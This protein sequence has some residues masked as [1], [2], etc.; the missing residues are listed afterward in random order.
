MGWIMVPGKGK[1]GSDFRLCH[2]CGGKIMGG[3]AHIVTHNNQWVF[4][5][6]C[7][8]I[9]QARDLKLEKEVERQLKEFAADCRKE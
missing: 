2:E 5:P 7:G 9:F 1:S 4:H 3:E 8:I 6:E